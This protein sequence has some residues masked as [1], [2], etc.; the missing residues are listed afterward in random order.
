MTEPRILFSDKHLVVAVK[1]QGIP[2]QRDMTGDKD[3]TVLLSEA[4]GKPV[5]PIHRLDRAV[6]GVMLFALTKEAAGKLSALVSGDGLEKEYLTALDGIPSK[7]SDTL[8]DH[9]L[10]DKR[11]NMTSVVPDGTKDAKPASLGY[12]VLRSEA[13]TSLLLVRLH[14]GRTHQI[15]VQ[16]SSRGLP[17]L[18]DSRY[19]NRARHNIALWS[20]RLGF[21][22]PFTKKKLVFS[23]LPE[24][25]EQPWALFEASDIT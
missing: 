11:R 13:N 10:H 24:M 15:R 17:I 19:G 3:M 25:T 8:N 20:Y 5:F 1:P 22:H 7:T 18:G 23:A 2:S 9:L 12:S 4:L 16:F 14:T 6:G 21:I